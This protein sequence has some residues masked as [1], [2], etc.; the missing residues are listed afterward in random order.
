[1]PICVNLNIGVTFALAILIALTLVGD[2]ILLEAAWLIKPWATPA[3]LPV[4]VLTEVASFNSEPTM[5]GLSRP[6]KALHTA[7]PAP[8]VF[9]PEAFRVTIIGAGVSIWVDCCCLK[10]LMVSGRFF[11]HYVHGLSICFSWLTR[12]NA[13]H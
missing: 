6:A 11:E 5:L 10:I 9:F 2:S 13:A 4:L 1:M 7:R 3:A 8:F 12:G